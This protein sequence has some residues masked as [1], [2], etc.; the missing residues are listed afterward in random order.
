MSRTSA[1]LSSC[2]STPQYR[3]NAATRRYSSSLSLSD[4]TSM[5]P[6]GENPVAMPVSPG[7]M[8]RYSSFV[9]LRIS[10]DVS[11][12][13]P[14]VTISP[15]ACHVVPLVS[16]SRSRR[17][18]FRHPSFA[19]W[20]AVDVPMIPPPTTTTSASAGT[21]PESPRTGGAVRGIQRG[22]WRSEEARIALAMG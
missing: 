22:R 17:T 12:R 19:R 16:V 2:T 6:T 4:A 3:L 5:K 15:A 21:P 11:D 20:Y 9:Y 18:T 13:D 14:K 8:L 7:R 10:V 1:G